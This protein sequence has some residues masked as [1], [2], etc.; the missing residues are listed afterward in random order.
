MTPSVIAPPIYA[1]SMRTSDLHFV[2]DRLP[3]N[4]A[5]PLHL[6]CTGAEV[7][8]GQV[9]VAAALAVSNYLDVVRGSLGSLNAV[10]GVAGLGGFGA[11]GEVSRNT[12][13]AVDTAS[14]FILDALGERDQRARID[15]E[16]AS[17]PLDACVEIELTVQC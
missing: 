12:S 4:D 16:V 2:S 3:V 10:K 15:L 7:T 6:G 14:Q 5:E 8:V 1:G 11:A 9:H 17:L 13:A